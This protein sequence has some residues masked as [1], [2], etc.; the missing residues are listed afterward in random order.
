M[1]RVTPPESGGQT[2]A[3]RTSIEHAEGDPVE[4]FMPYARTRMRGFR[5]GD[6]FAQA[7]TPRIF[8][9]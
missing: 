6:L 5:F 2:D 9:R 4:V 1:F 3:I 8:A 7:G